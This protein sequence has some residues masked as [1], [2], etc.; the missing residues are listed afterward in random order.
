MDSSELVRQGHLVSDWVS[1]MVPHS[2]VLIV[3]SRHNL[4]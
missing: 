4:H 3:I 1:A 2:V